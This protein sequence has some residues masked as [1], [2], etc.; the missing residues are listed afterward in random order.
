MERHRKRARLN[1]LAATESSNTS[2]NIPDVYGQRWREKEKLKEE[3]QQNPDNDE[4]EDLNLPVTSDTLAAAQYLINNQLPTSEKNKHLELVRKFP[5]IC[6][7]HQ[8]YSMLSDNTAVDR[9]LVIGLSLSMRKSIEA[10]L[11]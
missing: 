11:T 3:L 1:Y 7:V 5:R 6:F 2:D 9:E 8:I 10:S 4:F